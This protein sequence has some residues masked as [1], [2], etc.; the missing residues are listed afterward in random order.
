M[1]HIKIINS[2]IIEDS[3]GNQIIFGDPQPDVHTCGWVCSL[4]TIYY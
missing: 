4:K 2:E 1:I 3:D